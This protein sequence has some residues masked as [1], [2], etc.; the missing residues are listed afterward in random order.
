[1]P[2]QE[3]Y[4]V[5]TVLKAI[6]GSWGIKNQIAR[7]LNCD[8]GTVDNYISRHPTV[9]RA[10]EAERAKIVDAA[11]AQ[12]IKK[13]NDGDGQMIRFILATLGKDRGYVQRQE[14][15]GADGGPVEHK[16]SIFDYDNFGAAFGGLV[17]GH[18]EGDA[19]PDG[20]RKQV[21]TAAAN[22]KASRVPGAAKP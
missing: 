11:E 14:L 9:A 15:T 16:V 5:E 21:D 18:G 8:R 12:G 3:R 2:N 20:D 13:V 19:A 1:M 7:K 6:E 4:K 22:D 10:Y 17:G